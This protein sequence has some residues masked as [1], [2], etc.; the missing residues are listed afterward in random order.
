MNLKEIVEN[1]AAFLS[2][3]DKVLIPDLREMDLHGTAD[4]MRILLCLAEQYKKESENAK[5]RAERMERVN[6]ETGAGCG[7]KGRWDASDV[8]AEYD[9][10]LNLTLSELS[11]KSKWPV[12]ELTVLLRHGR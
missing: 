9:G 6:T 1:P 8:I 5:E 2:Y 7:S 4:D 11:R 12:G 10:N 3:I